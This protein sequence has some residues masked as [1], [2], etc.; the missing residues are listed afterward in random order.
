MDSTYGEFQGTELDPSLDF[1]YDEDEASDLPQILGLAAILA[2][3]VGVVLVLI[4]RRKEPTVAERAQEVLESASKEGKKSLKAA[5]KTVSKAAADARLGELLD[6][7]LDRARKAGA[8][9]DLTGLLSQARDKVARAAGS[10]GSVDL[11]EASK[12]A[13]ESAVVA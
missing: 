9:A 12:T 3:V 4:G 1:D 13:R 6:E 7:A 10:V 8:G 5:S 11:G 2:A